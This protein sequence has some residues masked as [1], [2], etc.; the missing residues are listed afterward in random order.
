MAERVWPVDWKPLQEQ[1]FHLEFGR[2]HNELGS[3][4]PV[5][6]SL[7]LE[8]RRELTSGHPLYGRPTT[9]VGFMQKCP[10]DFLFALNDEPGVF[11]WVHLTWRT[12]ASP[13]FPMSEMYK[14]WNDFSKRAPTAG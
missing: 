14:D 1:E 11:V 5:A 10:N 3:G 7:E 6:D 2:M 13:K 8:L 4:Q 12:E 9:A